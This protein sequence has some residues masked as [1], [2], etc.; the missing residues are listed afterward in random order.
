[1][2]QQLCKKSTKLTSISISVNLLNAA[3]NWTGS[4]KFQLKKKFN[5]FKWE[6]NV[7][8]KSQL[9]PKLVQTNLIN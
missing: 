4:F 2:H 6:Q 5:S 3:T 7:N 8:I 1:M 9:S